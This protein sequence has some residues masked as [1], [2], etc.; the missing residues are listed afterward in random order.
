VNADQ[1][2]ATLA[3][4]GAQLE[5]SVRAHGVQREVYNLLPGPEH[6]SANGEHVWKTGRV[7][8]LNW[9]AFLDRS[10]AR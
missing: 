5:V 10:E 9:S 2:L 3:A 7:R 8:G 6:T 1:L 4:A